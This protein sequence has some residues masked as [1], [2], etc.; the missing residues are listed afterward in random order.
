LASV[1]HVVHKCQ[2]AFI[3]D[4]VA[5]LTGN[6]DVAFLTAHKQ[7]LVIWDVQSLKISRE[8]MLGKLVIIDE[9]QLFEIPDP[10]HIVVDLQGVRVERD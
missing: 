5:F 7:E 2:F 1:V 9:F 4:D 6:R 3:I 10:L 8:I